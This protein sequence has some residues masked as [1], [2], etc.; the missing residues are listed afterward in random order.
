MKK[1]LFAFALIGALSSCSVTVPVTATG[2]P[3]GSKTGTSTARRVCGVWVQ[4]DASS[5]TAAKNGGITKIST[6]DCTTRRGL[7]CYKITTTVTG[8]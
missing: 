6:I 7:F 2:N 8:E 3:I 4:Q 1:A 5:V